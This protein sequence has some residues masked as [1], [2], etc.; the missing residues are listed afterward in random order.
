MA[1]RVGTDSLARSSPEPSKYKIRFTSAARKARALRKL[2]VSTDQLAIVPQITPLLK[3]N[4]GSLQPALLAMCFSQDPVVECFLAKRDSLGVWA[5]QNTS[6]EAIALGAGL[7]LL[8]LLGAALVAQRQHTM[9]VGKV[10]AVSQYPEVVRKRIEY[11][12][13][14]GGWR[15]RDYIQKLAGL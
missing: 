13:L 14:P 11:A 12:Q 8:H 10:I 5:R 2:G 1:R 6:W 15:D 7:D 4:R 3:D 9:T